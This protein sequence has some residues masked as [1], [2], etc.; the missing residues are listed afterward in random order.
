[1]CTCLHVVLLSGRSAAI[2]VVADTTVKEVQ[3]R[4]ETIFST[5]ISQ[6]IDAA[7]QTLSRASTIREAGLQ[8]G[9][10]LN[11]VARWPEI[12]STAPAFAL[13]RADGSVVTWGHKDGGGDSSKVQDQLHNVQEIRSTAGAFA[14]LRSDGSVITWGGREFGGDSAKVRD[15]LENVQARAI[16]SSILGCLPILCGVYAHDRTCNVHM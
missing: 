4:A 15:Q 5:G 6:L 11:A 13:R 7:G 14:A 1:M 9:D 12:A 10:S 8:D 16:D 2:R 3:S